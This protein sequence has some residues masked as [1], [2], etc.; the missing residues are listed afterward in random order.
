MD[1]E[2]RKVEI[3]MLHF[4]FDNT[5]E[6]RGFRKWKR[7]KT[8][9]QSFVKGTL[10]EKNPDLYSKYLVASEDTFQAKVFSEGRVYLS[11]HLSN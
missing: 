11:R 9:K 5:S 7:E 1:A 3:Q 6:I 10:K 4:E 2:L 8:T